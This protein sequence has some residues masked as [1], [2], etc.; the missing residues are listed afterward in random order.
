[1]SFLPFCDTLSFSLDSIQD[2]SSTCASLIP[3]YLTCCKAATKYLILVG[4]FNVILK[5]SVFIFTIYNFHTDLFKAC[6]S[7][8]NIVNEQFQSSVCLHV[9]LSMDV[10]GIHVE[11]NR[12]TQVLVVIFCLVS[13]SL[14]LIA[15]HIRL[16]PPILLR[17]Y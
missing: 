12:Q 13:D 10:H 3:L 8:L 1:M 16:L 14:S 17:Q 5:S 6:F 11:A 4:N 15:G 7:S 2:F 9:S